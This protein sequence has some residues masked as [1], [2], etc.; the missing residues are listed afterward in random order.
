MKNKE[1]KSIKY[2]A[3]CVVLPFDHT[4]NFAVVVSRSK[5]EIALFDERNERNVGQ[6]FM[7]MT[8]TYVWVIMVGWVDVLDSDWGDFR[9]RCAV[10]ISSLVLSTFT[11]ILRLYIDS[12]VKLFDKHMDKILQL[13]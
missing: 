11:F 13:A 6:S 7:T 3:D 2:L 1:S 12:D 4:H 10:H 5:F 8:V 9:R